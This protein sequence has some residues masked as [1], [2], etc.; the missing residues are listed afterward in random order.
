[1]S[2]PPQSPTTNINPENTYDTYEGEDYEEDMEERE[3]QEEAINHEMTVEQRKKTQRKLQ[4][5]VKTLQRV[6][7]SLK[8]FLQVWVTEEKDNQGTPITIHHHYWRTPRLRQLALKDAVNDT[9]D[10]P[11]LQDLYYGPPILSTLTGE[12]DRLIS[13][14]SFGQFDHTMDLDRLD[15]NQAFQSMQDIAPTWHALL[16]RLL[17][18]QRSHWDSYSATPDIDTLAKRLF[19]ITSLVSHSRAKKQSNFLCSILDMYLLGSGV[20]RRVIETL[21]GLGICHSYHQANRLIRDIA[22]NAKVSKLNFICLDSLITSEPI[23]I[24]KGFR[25]RKALLYPFLIF[26]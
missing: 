2:S 18:N 9:S 6:R 20:K 21:S 26:W 3:E 24:R 14:P 15:F 22:N 17:S 13:T 8:T 7:W 1:M 11:Y 23:S 10:I 25:S 4:M 12:F 16:I 19:M 5:I